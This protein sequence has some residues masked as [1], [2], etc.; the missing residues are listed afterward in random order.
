MMLRCREA[1]EP[2]RTLR[3][4]VVYVFDVS[5]TEGEPLPAPARVSGDPRDHTERLRG[6]V[7]ECG[8]SLEYQDSL[9]GPDGL[10][11]G[12]RIVLRRGLEPAEEFSVLVHELAHELLHRREG[13]SA[14]SK[15]VRETEA[16]AVAFVVGTAVG[17]ET[18]TASSD[19]IHSYRGDRD[20]L[21]AS[22]DRIQRVA[23]RI[24]T[25]VTADAESTWEGEPAHSTAA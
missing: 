24:I 21:A 25:A 3:F 19:Y 22:L 14:L 17:L 4:K 15:T 13:R 9:G 16:E 2:Q 10:S 23:T 8:I 18:S 1:A 6:L 7:A 20:T 12:G 11:C 5:Q